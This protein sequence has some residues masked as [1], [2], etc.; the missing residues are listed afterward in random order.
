MVKQLIMS[1]NLEIPFFTQDGL[2]GFFILLKEQFVGEKKNLIVD[3]QEGGV[4]SVYFVSELLPEHNEEIE[5]EPS[6]GM[7]LTAIIY[8]DL[9]NNKNIDLVIKLF[10]NIEVKENLKLEFHKGDEENGDYIYCYEDNDETT[11]LGD[12]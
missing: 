4:I 5:I 8:C 2:Y 6:N 7:P 11:Y 10:E 3:Y 12:T 1:M 9:L